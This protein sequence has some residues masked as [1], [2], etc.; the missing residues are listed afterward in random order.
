MLCIDVTHLVPGQAEA[1]AV[2]AGLGVEADLAVAGDRRRRIEGQRQAG[3]SPAPAR[4]HGSAASST[5]APRC[6]DQS[7]VHPPS[8]TDSGPCSVMP[9][10]TPWI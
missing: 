4:R 7:F 5:Q 9:P 8:A 6:L 10:N 2:D 3:V 1:G